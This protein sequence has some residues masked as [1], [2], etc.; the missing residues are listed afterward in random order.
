MQMRERTEGRAHASSYSAML[1]VM[2]GVGELRW[3]GLRWMGDAVSG[4]EKKEMGEGEWVR[5]EREETSSVEL[6]SSCC[7]AIRL[8]LVVILG[9]RVAL[10]RR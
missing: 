7:A 8:E 2:V 9:H 10:G 1:S 6:G 3:A 5:L 4:P